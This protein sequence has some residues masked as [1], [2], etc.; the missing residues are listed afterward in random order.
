MLA[1]AVTS[2]WFF[3]FLRAMIFWLAQVYV[4]P[5]W[6]G[7]V[8]S[9]LLPY[10]GHWL[11]QQSHLLQASS[12]AISK[13]WM[14]SYPLSSSV[15]QAHLNHCKEC[16]GHCWDARLG[17]FIF[18]PHPDLYLAST[19]MWITAAQIICTDYTQQFRHH[20]QGS[21]PVFLKSGLNNLN[22]RQN[23]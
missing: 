7:H 3:F 18:F 17:L 10:Y 6:Y 9:A 14:L 19:S 4:S 2:L 11:L 1:Q 8:L 5:T 23:I 21:K 16:V 12:T 13:L 22:I 15:T 20:L